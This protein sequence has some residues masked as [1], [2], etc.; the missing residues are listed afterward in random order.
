LQEAVRD[1][2]AV[3]EAGARARDVPADGLAGVQQV[4]QTRRV[5]GDVAA[6]GPVG[7]DDDINIV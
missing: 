6:L 3:Q 4:Q 2:E 5:L 1:A 7:E